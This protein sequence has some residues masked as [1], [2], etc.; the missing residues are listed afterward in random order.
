MSERCG[1]QQVAHLRLAGGSAPIGLPN[2]ADRAFGSPAP[3]STFRAS[4]RAFASNKRRQGA[5]LF[6]SSLTAFRP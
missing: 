5:E 3:S 1:G 2:F 4:V 6:I